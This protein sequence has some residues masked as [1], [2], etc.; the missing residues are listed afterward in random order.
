VRALLDEGLTPEQLDYYGLEYRYLTRLC[1][2][3]LSRDEAFDALET[4]IHKF[5]KRQESWFRRMERQGVEIEWLDG[6]RALHEQT[7]R[8]LRRLGPT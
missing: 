5:A 8:V 7:A 6:T 4:A 2:G 1:R 3:E